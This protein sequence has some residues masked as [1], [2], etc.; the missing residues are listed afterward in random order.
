MDPSRIGQ[1]TKLATSLSQ[2]DCDATHP[3]FTIVCA[4]G[5][6]RVIVENSL[7][8]SAASGMWGSVDLVCQKCGRY[9]EVAVAYE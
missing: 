5:S 3:Q 9:T 6:M 4:C 8:S 2:E 1:D 7:G